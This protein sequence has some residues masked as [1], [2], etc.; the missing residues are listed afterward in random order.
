MN[1]VTHILRLDFLPR[2][3]DFALLLLRIWIGASMLLL[4]GWGKLAGFSDRSQSFLNLFGIGSPATL[5]LAIFGEVFLSVLLILG[6][7]TRFAA[8]GG[9]ITMAVAFILVHEA[10][11]SGPNSGELAFIFL[12]AYT[13][14]FLTGGG[15]FSADAKMGGK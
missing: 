14:L 9:M 13:A 11:L 4:H 2:S 15:R 6:L 5:A 7:F 8:L 1:K 10:A 3:T 12:A